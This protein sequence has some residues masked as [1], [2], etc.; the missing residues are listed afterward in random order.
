MS[1]E[2]DIDLETLD[3]TTGLDASAGA[4]TPAPPDR[5]PAARGA[6]RPAAIVRTAAVL[7]GVGALAWL[8]YSLYAP[9]QRPRVTDTPATSE[10]RPPLPAP[11]SVPPSGERPFS[12]SRWLPPSAGRPSASPA[13]VPPSAG[14]S[15]PPGGSPPGPPPT[16]GRAVRRG[17]ARGPA[18]PLNEPLPA[19][20]CILVSADRRIAV[21]DGKIVEEHDAVGPR[22]LLRIEPDAVILREPS[23]YEVRVPVR[24]GPAAGGPQPASR[25]RARNSPVRFRAFDV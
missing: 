16:P 11:R 3:A 25:G 9:L 20:N 24:R 12:S 4:E 2:L 19:V 23:G 22:V 17:L 14:R 8:T 18:N 1:E 5:A 13:A 6:D 10:R 7:A 15:L 21:L